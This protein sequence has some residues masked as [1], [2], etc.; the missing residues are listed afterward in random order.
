VDTRYQGR[1]TVT[2]ENSAGALE[3]MSRFAIEPSRLWYLPP[4]MSPVAASKRDDALEHPDEAFA[5]YRQAGVD[6]VVCEEKHMG[7]RAVV[8]V[9][10]N[11]EVASRFGAGPPGAIYTRTGRSFFDADLTGALLSEVRAVVTAAD[12]WS[13]LRADWALL[14][15]ELLPWSAKAEGLIKDQYAATG[16]AARTALRAA[17]ELLEAAS[18]RGLDVSE[19]RGRTGRRARNAELFTAAYRRY[20]QPTDGLDGVT[21]AP[22]QVLASSDT[23]YEGR[24]HLWHLA[25][26]DRL[27]AVDPI[28]FTP[29]RRTTV[30]LA[31]PGSCQAGVTWW[32]DLTAAG[33]E[34]MVVKPLA[35]L[36]KHDGRLVQPGLKVRGREYLRIIYGPDYLDPANLA[37]LRSRNLAHKKAL[38]IREYALGLE[39]VARAAADEPL[40]RIHEMV[41]AVLALESEAVD[42]RL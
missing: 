32:E 1:I 42:P 38:A 18:T 17:T 29:T 41:F 10:R 2:A 5:A 4:T 27:V 40:W 14:D 7:S 28:R 22:F 6:Q 26:A 16:A 12:L 35:N 30:E 3:V 36:V 37:R 31:D 19:L 8:L 20:V 24:D 33:G 9:C 13:A 39:S 25:Q 11:D 21:L 23:T 15:C 34:G